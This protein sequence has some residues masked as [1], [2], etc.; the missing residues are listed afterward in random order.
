MLDALTAAFL[1]QDGL[2]SGVVYALVALSMVLLFS[3]TR[4]LFVAQGE[5]LAF[6][7]LSHSA[8][9]RG[10]VPGVVH[11]MLG[12]A[13]ACTALALRDAVRDARRGGTGSGGPIAR[14]VG[15][16]LVVPA[17]VGLLVFVLAPAKP[18][19]ALS[20][21]L[22]VAMITLMGGQLYRLAFEPIADASTLVLLFVSVALH[23][24]LQG[25]GLSAF[26]GEGWRVQPFWGARFTIGPLAV[27]GQVVVI[28][29]SAA[30]LLVGLWLFFSRTY[31]GQVLVATAC[32]RRGARLMGIRP[33]RAGRF[34]F[35][36]AAAIAAISGIL[37][38]P[39]ITIAYDSGFL[40]VL[41][42]LVAAVIGAMASYPVAA[43]GALLVGVAES[44]A[45]FHASA[46]K[47]ALVFLLLVPVVLWLSLRGGATHESEED[48]G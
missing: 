26:G 7:A 5:L 15:R 41:K 20:T 2:T 21:V 44:F 45:A 37:I 32:N 31:R 46:Y 8:L 3:V 29:T 10:V 28:W 16:E 22:V 18:H 24:V 43:L 42:G 36:L 35:G 12:M 9:E 11:L 19:P 33:E 40:I 6:A 1:I 38:A 25:V 39:T 30:A 47:E 48:A 14:A 34:A 13:I 4:V 27:S 23:F 17:L